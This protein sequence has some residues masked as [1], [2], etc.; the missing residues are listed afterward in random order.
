[1]NFTIIGNEIICSNY[2]EFKKVFANHSAA[3]KEIIY[4][5]DQLENEV[6]KGG[7]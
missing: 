7:K 3:L 4:N 2:P 5:R 1:M 6:I